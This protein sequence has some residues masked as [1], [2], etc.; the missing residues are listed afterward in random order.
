MSSF[1]DPLIVQIEQREISGRGLARLV[2]PFDFHV[3]SYPSRDVISIP[4]GFQTDFC[5]I[6]RF[7]MPFFPILGRAAKAAVVHDFLITQGK[8]THHQ[9]DQIF[10][11]AMRVLNVPRVRRLIMYL[12]VRIHWYPPVSWF[13]SITI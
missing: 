11:E 5:S 6:P 3:G 10:L 4:I 1:T 12:A 13:S 2:E 9:C 8:R 7:A